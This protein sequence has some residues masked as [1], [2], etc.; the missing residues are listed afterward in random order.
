MGD[1]NR[2]GGGAPV[3]L[4]AGG[5]QGQ[6]AANGVGVGPKN[7][8]HN[9]PKAD[10][11]QGGNN[12][13]QRGNGRNDGPGVNGRGNANGQQRVR[14]N[15]TGQNN[16][17]DVSPRVR[18]NESQA[19]QIRNRIENSQPKSERLGDDRSEERRVGKECRSRW[20]PY[21]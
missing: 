16:R 21:H 3:N 15:Q 5:G 19:Q 8:S 12:D 18:E 1:A 20:S 11:T 6:G 14:G 13:A 7:T 17:A 4:P 2:I 9:H 10:P